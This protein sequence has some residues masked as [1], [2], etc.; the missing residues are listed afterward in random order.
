M[1]ACQ[2]P[3]LVWNSCERWYASETMFE[4]IKVNDTYT[5]CVCQGP[6]CNVN[7]GMKCYSNPKR[8]EYDGDTTFQ[9]TSICPENNCA[10]KALCQTLSSCKTNTLSRFTEPSFTKEREIFPQLFM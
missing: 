10:D 3:W 4:V 5:K 9:H 6:L 8:E 7:E 2:E 1:Y